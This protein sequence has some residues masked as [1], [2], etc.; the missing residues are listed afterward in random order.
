MEHWETIWFSSQSWSETDRLFLALSLVCLYINI[1]FILFVY[2]LIWLLFCLR[3]FISS[4]SYVI[5]HF[6]HALVPFFWFTSFHIFA[7]QCSVHFLCCFHC[8]C[9]YHCACVCVHHYV[10][11]CVCPLVCVWIPDHFLCWNCRCLFLLFVPCV[12]HIGECGSSLFS[13]FCGTSLKATPLFFENAERVPVLFKCLKQNAGHCVTVFCG[14]LLRTAEPFLVALW[15][16]LAASQWVHSVR[17]QEP[18][19]L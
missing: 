12:L 1:F 17:Y 8:H 4:S 14:C 11:V 16:K 19:W 15:Y 2:L 18:G 9:V 7:S 13:S 3:L 5:E 6:G 10:C